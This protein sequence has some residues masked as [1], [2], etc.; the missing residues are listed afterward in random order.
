MEK[1]DAERGVGLVAEHRASF[2]IGPPTLFLGMMEVPD[3]RSRV[4]S[5]RVVSCGAPG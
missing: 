1:W 4:G 2:M 5:L 3:F